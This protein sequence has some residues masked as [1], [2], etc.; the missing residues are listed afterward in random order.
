M[1]QRRCFVLSWGAPSEEPLDELGDRFLRQTIRY[2]ENWVKHCDVPPIYQEEV[3]RSALALKLHCYEDTGAIVAALTTSIPEA[4]GTGRTWDYRYCWLRDAYYTLG[5]FRLLGHFDER[6]Q[7]SQYL[8]NVA[9]SAKDF[10]LAPLYRVDGKVDLEEHQLPNWAGYLGSGPVRVG[11]QAAVHRQ[12]DVFGEM[13]LALS[14]LF[15]DARFRGSV[16]QPVHELLTALARKAE[17]LA[18]QPDAGIW[19][20][21]TDWRPRPSAG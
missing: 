3:I 2:W 6:E 16:N 21:R 8:L 1:G 4:P 10:D 5:A 17:S 19:E 15:L 9:G 18:G 12:Y 14:P 13:V 7:F 20:Y 11:N